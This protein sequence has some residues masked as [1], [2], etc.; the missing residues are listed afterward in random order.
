MKSKIQATLSRQCIFEFIIPRLRHFT[1]LGQ[2][3]GQ[4]MPRYYT[5][6]QD[7]IRTE[8]GATKWLNQLYFISGI[9][10][11]L[12]DGLTNNTS[13]HFAHCS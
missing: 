8:S 11:P 4:N 5:V 12:F 3:K 6:E 1:I 9:I 10:N 2:K 13:G 7:K